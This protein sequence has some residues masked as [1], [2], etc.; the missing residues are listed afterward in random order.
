MFVERLVV[1]EQQQVMIRAHA[2][3]YAALQAE[4]NKL[5]ES[6]QKHA[7]QYQQDRQSEG[8]RI[9]AL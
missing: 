3:R 4:I 5:I 6:R 8:G 1:M 9:Y 7:M 2:A